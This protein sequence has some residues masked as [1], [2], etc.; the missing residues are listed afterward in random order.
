MP[1]VRERQTQLQTSTLNPRCQSFNFPTWEK[2][3]L[4]L[5]AKPQGGL[6]PAL[7]PNS[8]SFITPLSIKDCSGKEKGNVGVADSRLIWNRQLPAKLCAVGLGRGER[9]VAAAVGCGQAK[10]RPTIRISW[11]LPAGGRGQSGP[12]L[13]LL[14]TFPPISNLTRLFINSR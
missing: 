9:N 6:S 3:E 4:G 10:R 13:A 12:K 5:T 14:L 2:Q 8:N 7:L 1:R 11:V